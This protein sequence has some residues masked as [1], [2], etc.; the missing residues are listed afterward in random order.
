MRRRVTRR[1]IW[2]KV[3]WYSDNMFTNFERHWI[4][5]K[6]ESD[7]KYSRR[8]FIWRAN[9]LKGHHW[10][11]KFKRYRA[12][13]RRLKSLQRHKAWH[14]NISKWINMLLKYDRQWVLLTTNKIFPYSHIS[15]LKY[16]KRLV[17]Y[18]PPDPSCLPITKSI[19]FRISYYISRIRCDSSLLQYMNKKVPVNCVLML[20]RMCP[21]ECPNLRGF[22]ILEN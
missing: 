4:T 12:K 16:L 18:L 6:C 2:I 7:E 14:L 15:L 17:L 21:R 5:L 9:G 3:V 1:L 13:R 11:S 20:L 19:I 22:Y 8:Q 10:S